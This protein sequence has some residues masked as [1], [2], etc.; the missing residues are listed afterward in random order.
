MTAGFYHIIDVVDRVYSVAYVNRDVV[1]IGEHKMHIDKFRSS[2]I[3]F[4]VIPAPS[5]GQL[6]HCASTHDD[7]LGDLMG[8]IY[9]PI[10]D[11]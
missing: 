6:G 8:D 5:I 3:R 4:H 11:A 10:V 2:R 7:T 1:T 9:Y